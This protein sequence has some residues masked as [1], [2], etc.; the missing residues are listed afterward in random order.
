M[1]NFLFRTVQVLCILLAAAYAICTLCLLCT[2]EGQDAGK[3]MLFAAVI[4]YLVMRK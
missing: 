2:A 4:T 3:T 1:D